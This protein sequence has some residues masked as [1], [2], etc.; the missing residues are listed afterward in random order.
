MCKTPRFSWHSTSTCNNILSLNTLVTG[1]L[2]VIH[3]LNLF[4]LS[5]IDRLQATISQTSIASYSS[6]SQLSPVTTENPSYRIHPLACTLAC[7]WKCGSQLSACQCSCDASDVGL[8]LHLGRQDQGH[9][10]GHLSNS[11]AYHR[12]I[13]SRLLHPEYFHRSIRRLILKMICCELR[14]SMAG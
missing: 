12:S 8:C 5:D 6:R 7:A 1:E 13:G 10:N 11:K 2:L 9:R 4:G 14:Y 3:L